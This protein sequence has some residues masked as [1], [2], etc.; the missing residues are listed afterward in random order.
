MGWVDTTEEVERFCAR[1][2]DVDV[3]RFIA[4]QQPGTAFVRRGRVHYVKGYRCYYAG[5]WKGN[6]NWQND[7]AVVVD[8]NGVPFRLPFYE[9]EVLVKK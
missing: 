8:T 7:T 5:I 1:C 2:T 4:E 9:D 3:V 6:I